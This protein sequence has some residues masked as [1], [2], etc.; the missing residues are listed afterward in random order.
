MSPFQRTSLPG[1][2]YITNYVS[3]SNDT[4]SP[5][6]ITDLQ[7]NDVSSEL[8]ADGEKRNYKVIWTATG[9]DKNIGQ[10]N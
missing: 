9:N 1:V 6:R 2:I 7:V 3:N 4:T 5:G 8:Q 10:G